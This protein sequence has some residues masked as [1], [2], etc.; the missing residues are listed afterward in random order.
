[1]TRSV[2]CEPLPRT[3]RKRIA[4]GGV[5]ALSGV[6]GTGLAW[7]QTNA[8]RSEPPAIV[9]NGVPVTKVRHHG[10]E[11]PLSDFHADTVTA[12]VIA[13]LSAQTGYIWAFDTQTEADRFNAALIE[14]ERNCWVPGTCSAQPGITANPGT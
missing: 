4:V 3:S 10:T 2:R 7:Q 9:V 11:T 8:P 1:M 14:L 13:P 12:T 5:L 6:V